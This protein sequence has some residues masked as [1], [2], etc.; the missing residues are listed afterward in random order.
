MIKS[1]FLR[2]EILY[3][4][5]LE[6]RWLLLRKPLGG[7]RGSEVDSMESESFHK[8]AF[9]SNGNMIGVGRI[10]F[11]GNIAQIRYMAIIKQFRSKGFG[12]KLITELEK[13]AVESDMKKIFLNS[14]ISAVNFY[15]KNGY[16]KIKK[17]S[18]SFGDIIHYRMEKII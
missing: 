17:V 13:I 10:H 14:R 18:P 8:A 9:D 12:S 4:Q 11:I 2:N 15:I 6:L 3:N 1:V 7:I 5:Y 16:Q